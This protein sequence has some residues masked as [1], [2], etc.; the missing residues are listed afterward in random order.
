MRRL[1]LAVALVVSGCATAPAPQ[2]QP[3]IPST[4]APRPQTSLI[5]MTAGELI[6]RFGSP[7]IQVREGAGLKLQF[8]AANCVL[9]T[10]LY[11]SGSGAAERVTHVEARLPSGAD[12]DSRGCIAALDAS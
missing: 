12:T 4:P 10:Y 6:Q 8:R 3:A 2:P 1:L 7:R 11:A 9:D 5:G